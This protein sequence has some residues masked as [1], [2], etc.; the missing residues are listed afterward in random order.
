MKRITIYASNAYFKSVEIVIMWQKKQRS[1]FYGD[2]FFAT[3]RID[4]P[5]YSRISGRGNDRHKY[6]Q[7]DE[8]QPY[9]FNKVKS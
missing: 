1:D 9:D 2:I 3:H 5:A 4:G 7:D 8:V 6:Y